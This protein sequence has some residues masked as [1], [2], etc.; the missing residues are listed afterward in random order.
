[1]SDL[2]LERWKALFA[3]KAAPAIGKRRYLTSG[4]GS[5]GEAV[6][7]PYDGW[8]IDTLA[9]KYLLH[10]VDTQQNEI[11]SLRSR[12]DLLEKMAME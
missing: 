1:M 10:V 3:N 7:G 6:P 2:D 11:K 9:I 4:G 12:V 8:E 5:G